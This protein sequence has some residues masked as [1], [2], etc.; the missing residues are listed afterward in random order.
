MFHRDGAQALS[1]E[2][3]VRSPKLGGL[4]PRARLFVVE[5]LPS[6]VIRL[7][8]IVPPS[9]RN[10]LCNKGQR[11]RLFQHAASPGITPVC[12]G[13]SKP[14]AG[15]QTARKPAKRIIFDGCKRIGGRMGRCRGLSSCASSGARARKS[16]ERITFSNCESA[17]EWDTVETRCPF[18]LTRR[19]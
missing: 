1:S 13:I 17:A 16:T 5:P 18:L 14:A 9:N 6:C 12:T 7:S 11:S 15:S 4:I 2:A 19:N 3:A 8:C 10:S